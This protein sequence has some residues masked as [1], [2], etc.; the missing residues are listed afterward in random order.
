MIKKG[1]KD[2]LKCLKYYLVPFG[3]LSIFFVIGLSGA[4]TGISNTVKDFITG[5]NEL[6]HK[7]SINWSGMWNAIVGEV[8]KVDYNQSLN[9]IAG[10]FFSKEWLLGTLKAIANAMFGDSITMD[11]IQNLLNNALTGLILALTLFIFMIILGFVLGIVLM[12]LLLRKELTHIKVGR[13]LLYSLID[14]V[15]W[16]L[17]IIGI[18]KLGSLASWTKIVIPVLV[19]LLLPLF[20]LME[21][22]VFYGIKKIKFK[23]AIKFTNVLK[24]YL[25]D[26]IIVLISAAITGLCLLIFK[27]FTAIYLAIPIV[28]IGIITIGLESENYIVNL[29]EKK[30]LDTEAPIEKIA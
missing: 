12:K 15:I 14:A 20:C 17:V 3:I 24:I 10:T 26:L 23:D 4:I 25:I 6:A 27:R 8:M 16:I 13:L 11:D 7:A 18:A 1:I 29:V 5:A 19:L 28:E 30:P 21:G 9:G 2:Y 22:Y